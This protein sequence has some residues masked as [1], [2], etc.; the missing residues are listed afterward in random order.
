MKHSI[1]LFSNRRD[2]TLIKYFLSYF[3]IL[4]ILFLGFFFAVR[5]QLNR[6]YFRDLSSQADMR[7]R[8][9]VSQLE[10]NLSGINQVQSLLSR[11]INLVLSRYKNENWYS[12]QAAQRMNEYTISNGF[13]DTIVYID[14]RKGEI[15]SSG[16]H[17]YK[18][19]DIYYVYTGSHYLPFALGDYSAA[20]KSQL[21]Y[22]ADD[23]SGMLIYLPYNSNIDSY[24]LFYIIS[25]K[26]LK[27]L[28]ESG[29]FTG[30]NS[31]C[32]IS[33]DHR[34]VSGIHSEALPF[35]VEDLPLDSGNY[36]GN[37]GE[38][39]FVYSGLPGDF[40]LLAV[41]SNNVWLEQV[42]L[43]FRNTYLILVLLATCGILLILFSMRITYWPLHQL[44]NKLV[45]KPQ[46]G[47]SYVEQIDAAFTTA[48]SEKQELQNKLDKY[49]ISM[50]KSILD[51]I[52]SDQG[53]VETNNLLNIDRF[54]NDEDDNVIFVIKITPPHSKKRSIPIPL[55]N[56]WKMPCLKKIP[57]PFWKQE[58]ITAYL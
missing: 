57:A 56:T 49:R 40:S 21:I 17:V 34:I 43:A 30:I 1:R 58:I 52:V 41:A 24:S 7:L 13:I 10:D 44:L 2:Y 11:D 4:S 35:P 51:S 39:L 26:E 54:F 48:I 12:Y 31:V 42:N 32:L 29:C 33:P 53:R 55:W 47:R 3:V 15:L 19:D 9:V 25:A 37:A 36:P 18:Q 16:R 20:D 14:N 22:L 46:P 28:L 38:N 27:T 6:I 50:Q 23:A 8:N 5:I 45:D